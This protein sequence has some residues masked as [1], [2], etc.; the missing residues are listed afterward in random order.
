M[1]REL[2]ASLILACAKDCCRELC[3]QKGEPPCW[4]VDADEGDPWATCEACES[5]S[6]L[7]AS[8]RRQREATEARAE[9][10]ALNIHAIEGERDA[11]FTRVAT[12]EEKLAAVVAAV[13]QAVAGYRAGRAIARNAVYA[14]A[15]GMVLAAEAIRDL[16]ST[17]AGADRRNGTE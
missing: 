1:S 9:R 3:A 17:I 5:A 4:Q 16:I 8:E 10:C 7:I 11:A 12:L 14:H 13:R 2:D 6:I 15:D